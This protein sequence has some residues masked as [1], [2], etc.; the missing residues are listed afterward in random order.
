MTLSADKV[1]QLQDVISK[2]KQNAN[3]DNMRNMILKYHEVMATMEADDKKL[4]D[5]L[6]A[7]RWLA[8]KD[9]RPKDRRAVSPVPGAAAFAALTMPKKMIQI[10]KANA[11][12]NGLLRANYMP[13]EEFDELV[14]KGDE[15]EKQLA[16][17]KRLGDGVFRGNGEPPTVPALANGEQDDVMTEVQK[18][19]YAKNSVDAISLFG[20]T[21]N[22]LEMKTWVDKC[23]KRFNGA[24]YSWVMR[25]M[26]DT[27]IIENCEAFQVKLV[28]MEPTGTSGATPSSLGGDDADEEPSGSMSTKTKLQKMVATRMRDLAEVIGTRKS[29][30]A[31][32]GAM[33]QHF[34]LLVTPANRDSLDRIMNIE[35]KSEFFEGMWKEF[36]DAKQAT[37]DEIR[38]DKNPSDRLLKLYEAF[39]IK[40]AA[41]FFNHIKIEVEKNPT[42]KLQRLASRDA[43][44]EE[45][46]AQFRNTS[47]DSL[48]QAIFNMED[49][50]NAINAHREPATQ[51]APA[52]LQQRPLRGPNTETLIHGPFCHVCQV[53]T[54]TGKDAHDAN[55]CPF[56]FGRTPPPSPRGRGFGP[57]QAPR[58][59]RGGRG[60]PW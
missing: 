60:R 24:L 42:R 28:T 13:D 39:L 10:N 1:K 41:I 49:E 14:K 50:R 8:I 16:E 32:K 11:V 54:G 37:P 33:Y 9:S 15:L 44:E 19:Q 2:F 56:R 25:N 22:T 43:D 48:V 40:V 35:K 20:P 17:E 36:R 6:R 59:G 58:G 12:L 21:E 52:A 29:G 47:T 4:H 30:L 3:D 27:K 53:R 46:E 18:T 45:L 38:A 23:V 57:G 55:T 7:I 31:V 26:D 5:K 51:A 34:C